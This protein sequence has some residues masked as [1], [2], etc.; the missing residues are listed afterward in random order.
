MGAPHPEAIRL[1]L[2]WCVDRVVEW[3]V[4]RPRPI[5]GYV[6]KFRR[7]SELGLDDGERFKGSNITNFASQK[8]A[9]Q[10]TM[11]SVILVSI[12]ISSI[13]RRPTGYVV[14]ASTPTTATVT[15]RAKPIA[16]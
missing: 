8:N 15:P 1:A 4:L 14:P 16:R 12:D 3:R 2:A 11:S 9:G 7:S 10:N 6:R 13:M 5:D